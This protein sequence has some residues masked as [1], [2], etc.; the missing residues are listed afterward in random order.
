LESY[1]FSA[2]Y[3]G[4]VSVMSFPSFEN[5]S[6]RRSLPVWNTRQL[7]KCYFFVPTSGASCMWLASRVV[8]T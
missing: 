3:N 7:P 4:L 8:T 2:N 1:L 6:K 5:I